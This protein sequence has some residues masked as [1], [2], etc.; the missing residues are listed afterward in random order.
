MATILESRVAAF[1]IDLEKP[2]SVT[3][4]V[5]GV[6]SL[7]RLVACRPVEAGEGRGEGCACTAVRIQ[8]TLCNPYKHPRRG[9]FVY[10]V[11]G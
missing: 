5:T 8:A 6:V 10:P 2:R 1:K 11:P 9:G 7:T 3:R 4:L